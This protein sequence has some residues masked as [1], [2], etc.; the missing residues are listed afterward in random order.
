MRALG[1]RIPRLDAELQVQGKLRF[2]DDLDI[3][4]LLCGKVL[5]SSEAHADIVDIDTSEAE[6]IEGV[7]AVITARDVPF[8][9]WGIMLDDRGARL[10]DDKAVLSAKRVFYRGD[11]VAAVAAVTPEIALKALDKIK[12]TYRRLPAVFDPV[13]AMKP[14]SPK[15]HGSDNVA[16]RRYLRR[17]DVEE[18]FGQSDFVIEDVFSSPMIEHASMEPHACIARYEPDGAFTIWSSTQ[19]PFVVVADV[20]RVLEV[21]LSKV[22]LITPPVGGGFGGKNEM[23]VEAIACLLSRKSGSPVKIVYTRE[24]EMTASTVRHPYV[25]TF[26]SGVKKDGTL[27]SRYV[28][29]ISNTGP[30]VGVGART[31]ERAVNFCC[32][33]YVIPHVLVEGFLVYT[34]C[35]DGGA[36][37]GF[38]V[39]QTIFACEVH[40][41]RIAREL[42]VDPLEFRLKNALR[43]GA[44]MMNGQILQK[45]NVVETLRVAAERSGWGSDQRQRGCRG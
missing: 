11:G 20:A 15:I 16:T 1:A 40:T 24:E 14:E 43:D 39:P 25:M 21:P 7:A 9:S 4:G 17:G 19:R 32:G 10:P 18:G 30:Y 29:I 28:K 2:T 3:P 12:V 33:P 23:T 22:R 38:G 45:S 26:K 34:N 42:G 35:N 36:M 31:L 41:D 27:L 8:N 5:R 6:S 44:T 13:E 37:R